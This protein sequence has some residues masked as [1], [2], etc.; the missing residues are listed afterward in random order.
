MEERIN[1]YT[2]FLTYKDITFHFIFDKMELRLIPPKDK[3]REVHKWFL[4]SLG[5]GKYSIDF[6]PRYIE[7]P[8]FTGKS[9]ETNQTLI[10]I[11]DKNKQVGISNSAL[12]VAVT[13]YAILKYDRNIMDRISFHSPELDC[14][15][16]INEALDTAQ[17][18]EDGVLSLTTKNFDSTTTEKQ[19][20]SVDKKNI[21]VRFGV[22]RTISTKV[23]EPPLSLH[24]S[25]VFEFEPTSDYTFIYRLWRI[26]K[27]FIQYLCYRKNIF[28]PSANIAA[29][30]ADGKH[31]DFATFYVVNETEKAEESDTLT[32]GRYIK[33]SSIAGN[34]GKILSDIASDMIYLRHLP[35]SYESGEYIN[36]A[37]FVMITA[38]FEWE[39]HR[40]YPDGIKKKET[41]TTAEREVTQKID[42][43]ISNSGGKKR[44]IYKFLKK[45]IKSNSLQSEIEQIGKDYSS[46]IDLFGKHLYSINGETLKY[47]EMGWR[48]GE[49]R[50]HFAHGDLDENFIGPSLLDLMYLEYIVYAIQLKSY[51]ILD[52][53]IKEAI[54]DLFHCGMIIDN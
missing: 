16:P 38:A 39:F 48:L 8:F 41:T 31:E 45:L 49:Q 2:G 33:Y 11:I 18:T 1:I 29:P 25:M 21:N 15:Y 20:F 7:D 9:Y 52:K 10:F 27:S 44:S 26:A 13:A 43:L 24:S 23:G 51:D 32:S 42:E 47:S 22:S 19:C 5:N 17:W 3:E 54:N 28:L 14:I 37:R 12:F 6:N 53:N 30:Y 35:E 46:I 4:K 36:A 50:N 34:E 40:N